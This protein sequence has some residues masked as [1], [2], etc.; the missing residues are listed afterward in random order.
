[1][2]NMVAVRARAVQGPLN[3]VRLRRRKVA[4]AVRGR[5][6]TGPAVTGIAGIVA[7]EAAPLCRSWREPED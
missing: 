4:A 3:Q 1:M 5:T 7:Y 6:D 2:A